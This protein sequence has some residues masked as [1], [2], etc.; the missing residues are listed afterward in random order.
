[1][2]SYDLLLYQSETARNLLNLI[3]LKNRY[4]EFVAK[5]VGYFELHI[6]G[7]VA[8]CFPF[9]QIYVE[10]LSLSVNVGFPLGLKFL[11]QGL[12]GQSKIF[13]CQLLSP[14]NDFLF[15]R[16]LV[17]VDLLLQKLAFI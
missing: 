17:E 4:F 5:S 8:I 9:L 6:D 1:L 15:G 11:N 2:V 13:D 3:L 7:V 12:F 16:L 10:Y 14:L